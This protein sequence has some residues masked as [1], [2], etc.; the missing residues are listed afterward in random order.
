PKQLLKK[1]NKLGF[2]KDRTTGSHI[3]M[4]HQQTKRRAVV[5]IHL[6]DIPK[7]TLNSLL[8]EAGILREE[9]LRK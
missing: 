7:G 1:L 6:R 3:V 5:P 4:Y 8:K 2:T 9:L